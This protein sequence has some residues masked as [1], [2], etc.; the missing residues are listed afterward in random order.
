ML[1]INPDT[2]L[3]ST[4]LIMMVSVT[5]FVF[6]IHSLKGSKLPIASI[7]LFQLYFILGA[8]GWIIGGIEKLNDMPIDFTRGSVFYVICNFI[9]FTAVIECSRKWKT[10]WIIG[11]AHL[12]LILVLM[13][14]P[15]VSKSLI[16]ISFY[17]LLLFPAIL[18]VS[19]KR[20]I[21]H[22]NIGY[23][24][25][26]LAVLIVLLAAPAQ[27]FYTWVNRAPST[28]Y[29]IT[30]VSAATGYILV[31]IGF[32]TSILIN[33]HRLLSTMALKDPLTGLL[34]RR[35]MDYA[36]SVVL[37]ASKRN[38]TS[39]SVIAIDIDYFKKIND[40]Y[41]HD[42]GDQVLKSI[43]SILL[44]SQRASDVCCRLG[45]EEF[46]V[47]LPESDINNAQLIAERLRKAFEDHLV[48][49]EEQRI[50]LTASFG[51]ASVTDGDIDSALKNADKAL[52]QAKT[53]GRN[54]VCTAG[55]IN[56]AHP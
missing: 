50:K 16:F 34:N 30:F 33:E 4:Y 47:V 22:R 56:P 1:A 9:L 21:K 35:G 6:I 49:F 8:I 39:I 7:K 31:G 51:I 37:A 2:Y 53:E 20:A 55:E 17:V 44:N 29:S 25:I 45:G 23:L 3:F 38:K 28:S 43:A 27:I 5:S 26:A 52:Y 12:I 24:I 11:F 19:V 41:G 14:T 48:E 46:L 18:F 40:N 13:L 32:L 54:R 42:G 15:D 36:L 10:T